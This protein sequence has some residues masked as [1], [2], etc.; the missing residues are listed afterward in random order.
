MAFLSTQYFNFRNLK[1]KRLDLGAREIFMVGENGQGKTNFIESIYLLCFGASFRTSQDLRMINHL[2]ET[3]VVRGISREDERVQT[4]VAVKV[5][6]KSKKEIRIDAKPVQDRKELIEKNPCIIF[7]HQDMELITGAPEKRRRFFNQTLTLFDPLFLEV[8]RRYQRAVRNR[9]IL[10]KEKRLEL[11][12]SY[13]RTMAGLGMSIQKKRAEIIEEFNFAFCSLFKEISGLKDELSI[14]YRPSW[15]AN[16]SREDILG[17]LQGQRER[18]IMLC[19]SSS[20]P[21]RDLFL[22]M[23]GEKEFAS[24][25]S[26]GQIRLSALILRAAQAH[27]FVSKSGRKPLL[28]LD[29]VLLE[30]DS[31]K[32]EG[33][34]RNLPGYEQAF[35]TFLP[36]ESYERYRGSDTL[37]YTVK[38]GEF[39]PASWASR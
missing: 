5:S 18:D 26:T 17:H 13:D 3:A 30:L 10:L 28:L 19:S 35:F 39:L 15:K 31:R 37:L 29:D 21:H 16:A 22:L 27:F 1:N 4:E 14:L 32:R 7:S 23:Q 36:H 33:F 12:P 34:L 6:S 2:E 20:G 38:E 25:G 11:L 9:N 8:L 24:I